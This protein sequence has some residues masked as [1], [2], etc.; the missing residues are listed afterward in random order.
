MDSRSGLSSLFLLAC[1]AACAI[2]AHAIQGDELTTCASYHVEDADECFGAVNETA[3]VSRSGA[4]RFRLYRMEDPGDRCTGVYEDPWIRRAGGSRF[5]RVRA[6]GSFAIEAGRAGGV[7][8]FKLSPNATVAP[9]EGAAP[10]S[11]NPRL[12]IGTRQ[13]SGMIETT[14]IDEIQIGRG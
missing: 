5:Y 11:R 9:R 3:T 13:P 14:S 10:A 1:M 6:R 12:V 2:D 8:T 7:L 4:V